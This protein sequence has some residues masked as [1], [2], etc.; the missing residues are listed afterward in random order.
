MAPSPLL[1]AFVLAAALLRVAAALPCRSSC[2][3]VQ[4]DYPFGIDDGCGTP[5]LRG[6]LSCNGTSGL[7]LQTPSGAYKVESIDYQKQRVMV[8]D[9]SMST[10]S[11]LQPHHDFVMS[12]VQ[13]AVMPPADD[14]VFA[15]LNCSIDSPV[16][17]HYRYLCFNDVAGHSCNELYGACNAFR[18]FHMSSN[19]TAPACCFTRYSTVRFMSMNM[20]DCTHYTTVVGAAGEGL[21]SIGPTDWVYGIGLSYAVPPGLGCERCK[22]SG[23]ACGFDTDSGAEMCLCSSTMNATR[24]CGSVMDGGERT[25]PVILL[26]GFVMALCCLLFNFMS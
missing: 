14:T 4:I 5:Q 22:K 18:L 9:P 6:W 26:H 24:E 21:R 3:E 11:I 25:A 16:L 1:M 2:G 17:N 10:C 19:T 8:Y 13:Y 20:L 12:D 23:G 7:F 15:L